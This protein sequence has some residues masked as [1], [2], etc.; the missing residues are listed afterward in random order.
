MIK[1][2]SLPFEGGAQGVDKA[3]AMIDTKIKKAGMIAAFREASEASRV[4]ARR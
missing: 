4:C 1:P 3:L 2:R